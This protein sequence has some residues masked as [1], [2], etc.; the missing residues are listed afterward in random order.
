MIEWVGLSGG[1]K[2]VRVDADTKTLET[3]C[4]QDKAAVVNVI[5]PQQA[6]RI[7][8]VA[9]VADRSGWCPIDPV[10]FESKLQP[11]VHVI[12]D[13]CIAGGM[14]KSAFSANPQAKTC[15]AAVTSLL[16]GRT[17]PAPKLVNTCYS[18]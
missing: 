18:L 13:A 5:P 12:G 1:G 7:A 15:P 8:L 16:R 4:G 3:E 6:G 10:T 14:P 9:G 11:N 2:V 17:A